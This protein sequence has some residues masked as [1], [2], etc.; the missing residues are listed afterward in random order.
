MLFRWAADSSPE[1]PGHIAN[2]K[3]VRRK[4]LYALSE[5]TNLLLFSWPGNTLT[6]IACP[7]GGL[8]HVQE[9]VCIYKED[10]HGLF[11]DLPPKISLAVPSF[12]PV[13][14]ADVQLRFE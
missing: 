7:G 12:I 5:N 4:F 1:L 3:H 6:G 11:P 10:L 14:K 2:S 9:G 8:V 13:P